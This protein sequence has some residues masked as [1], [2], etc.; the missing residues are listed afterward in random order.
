MSFYLLNLAALKNLPAVLGFLAEPC[1]D[2]ACPQMSLSMWVPSADL[3]SPRLAGTVGEGAVSVMIWVWGLVG[4]QP[5]L[6][7]GSLICHVR[8]IRE[9]VSCPC[10]DE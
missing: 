9:D 1:G 10:E 5:S 6:A 8:L 2:R 7:M 4:E 3:Q